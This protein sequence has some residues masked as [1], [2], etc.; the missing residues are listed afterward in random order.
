MIKAGAIRA[1]FAQQARGDFGTCSGQGTKEMVIRMLGKE[2]FDLGAVGFDL[3]L[4]HAQHPGARQ[5]QPALGAGEHLAGDELAGPRENL[6]AL[7]IGLRS[8]QLVAVQELFPFAFACS[9]Q[10]L[11]AGEGFQKGPS[12][13][14]RPVLKGFQGGR[15][16]F[17][18]STLELIDQGSAFLDQGHFVAA[19]QPQLGDQRVLFGEC[20]PALPIDAQG[21]GQTPGVEPVGLAPTGGFARAVSLTAHRRNRIEAHATFQ[22]LLDN[23]ALAGLHTD[24]YSRAQRGD[25]LAPALPA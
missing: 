24:R 19:K 1:D 7:G 23:H 5:N 6:Q 25:L 15:I 4:E 2:L 14:Q 18:Q 20:F 8:G 9:A 13:R 10:D 11:R 21:I 22:Q 3:V 12:R 16:V 17:L